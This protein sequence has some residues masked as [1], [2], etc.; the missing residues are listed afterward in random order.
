MLVDAVFDEDYEFDIIFVE[1]VIKKGKLQDTSR[2][3]HNLVT[4][5]FLLRFSTKIISNS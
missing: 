3:G 5:A 2:F 4:F 1:N